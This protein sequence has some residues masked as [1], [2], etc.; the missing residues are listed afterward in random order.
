MS[1][2]IVQCLL[3]VT[4]KFKRKHM[5][6]SI[7]GHDGSMLIFT[8]QTKRNVINY[9]I[10]SALREGL[11]EKRENKKIALSEEESG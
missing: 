3:S 2:E 6:V 5:S 7:V 11:L 10:L 9:L 8:E 1:F 4:R